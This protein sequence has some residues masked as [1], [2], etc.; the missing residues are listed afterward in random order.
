[1]R[2]FQSINYMHVTERRD[3]QLKT[4][5]GILVI[6]YLD[7]SES[8]R[9]AII[10]NYVHNNINSVINQ[11]VNSHFHI[12]ELKIVLTDSGKLPAGTSCCAV[13]IRFQ[14]LKSNSPFSARLSW[15]PGYSWSH[16]CPEPGEGLIAKTWTND[17]WNVTVGTED[18]EYLAARSQT[19]KWMPARMLRSIQDNVDE[20]VNVFEESILLTLPNLE[21]GDI[22]QLQFVIA[23]GRKTGSD[24]ATWLAV[25]RSPASILD[26]AG[27]I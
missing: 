10:N 9:F 1:M 21:L 24:I 15:L 19:E 25:D 20:I 18:T 12:E 17:T 13:L 5:L 14:C 8:N 11:I 26:A 2:L 4:P 16:S 23:S 6:E 22:C 27:C 7:L 3:S